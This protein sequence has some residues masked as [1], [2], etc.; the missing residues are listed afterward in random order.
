MSSE[1]AAHKGAI[2]FADFHPVE[3]VLATGSADQ[4]VRGG[5]VWA[6]PSGTYPAVD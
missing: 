4:S 6:A 1:L 3:V 5:C 2:T